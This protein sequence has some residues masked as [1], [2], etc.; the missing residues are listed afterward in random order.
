MENGNVHPLL[1][2]FFN[3]EALRR[4]DVFQIHPTERRLHGGDHVDQL[5]G[6]VLIQFDIENVNSG[7]F[8][9]QAAF[10]LHHRLGRQRA[11]IAKSE[12]GRA[13]GDDANQIGA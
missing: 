6:V 10:A 12:H 3:I 5:V 8:L 9:E 13:V 11:N 1:E 7:E 2:L 4:L